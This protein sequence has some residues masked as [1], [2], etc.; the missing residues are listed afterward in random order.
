METL[1]GV[2]VGDGAQRTVLLV[3]DVHWADWST[4]DFLT[5]TTRNLPERR[6][7]ILLTWRD[8]AAHASACPGSESCY[9]ARAWST[10]R[11]G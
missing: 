4:L 1:T 9:A 5:L 11:A 10:C 3:E 7:L 8:E 6:L 2:L